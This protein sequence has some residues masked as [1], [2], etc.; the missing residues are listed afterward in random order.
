MRCLAKTLKNEL[1]KFD[2]ESGSDYC[3]I[4]ITQR[5]F[6]YNKMKNDVAR[7]AWKAWV[8]SDHMD[9]FPEVCRG[10]IC[11]AKTRAGTPCKRTDLYTGGR[12]NLHGGLSTG[13]RTKKGKKRSSQNWKGTN[14]MRT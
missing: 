11:G 5:S 1:C 7:E 10:L 3:R 8:K 9:P 4:H 2:A 12:C 13:P 6:T 14:P